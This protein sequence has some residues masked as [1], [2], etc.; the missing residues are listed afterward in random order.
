[1]REAISAAERLT[2]TF[3]Y[4]ASGDDQQSLSFS[5]RFGRTTVSHIIKE[6]LHAIWLALKDKYVS[7]DL[8]PPLTGRIFQRTLNPFGICRIVLGQLTENM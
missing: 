8:N 6:T 2:L 3:R 7:P 4:L 5:Y 1:M